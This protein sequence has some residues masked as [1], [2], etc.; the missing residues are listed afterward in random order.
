MVF[1]C[2]MFYIFVIQ[3]HVLSDIS[4]FYIVVDLLG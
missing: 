1:I 3:T 2:I 4:D